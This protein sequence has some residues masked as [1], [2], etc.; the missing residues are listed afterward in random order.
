MDRAVTLMGRVLDGRYRVEGKIGEGGMGV[1]LAA[2]HLG[3][4]HRV[5]IKLMR[6]DADPVWRRR[7]MR[8]A[9]AASRIDSEHVARVFDVGVTDDG[10]PFLTMEYLEGRD[11]AD[12]MDD[13]PL[14][15]EDAVEYGIQ[16]C[17]ALAA[18]HD[19]GIV[20]RDVKPANLFVARREDGTSSVKLLDF[21][22]SKHGGELGGTLTG[23]HAVLGSP[24][25][26]SPEQLASSR[27][28]D[29]RADLWSLGATLFELLTLEHAFE[30]ASLAEL[31]TAIMRDPPRELADYRIDAPLELDVIIGQCLEKDRERR[32]ASARELMARLEA[33]REQPSVSE[34]PRS[35][36]SL[37]APPV[38]TLVMSPQELAE[39]TPLASVRPVVLEREPHESPLGNDVTLA[40]AADG[41]P[42]G[43]DGAVTTAPAR[44]ERRRQNRRRQLVAA[45]VGLG[46]FALAL[47]T[48][49]PPTPTTQL[50]PAVELAR[51]AQAESPIPFAPP[52]APREA[53]PAP[54]PSHLVPSRFSD[55]GLIDDA[56][57][58]QIEDEL[59]KA[60]V[61]LAT[62]DHATA[63]R[64][65]NVALQRLRDVGIR[66][67]ES[68]SSLGA[69]VT[70][71]R[72]EVEGAALLALLD[73]PSDRPLDRAAAERLVPELERRLGRAQLAYQQVRGWGV[74][75]FYRCAV[76]ETAALHLAVG[77]AFAAARANDAGLENREWLTRGAAAWLRLARAG[78][79][80]ALR[81]PAETTLCAADARDGLAGTD[82]V[83]ATLTARARR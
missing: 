69:R 41:E 32:I 12:I 68:V 25:F 61:A 56:H 9:Q 6:A 66:P 16:A 21:G 74:A 82:R 27:D 45:L 78:Y 42:I 4:G 55:S 71:L 2:R 34:R 75:S 44:V 39:D 73:A 10:S 28:V 64:R 18:A 83:L 79:R 70:L 15:V 23:T 58:R 63:R 13:G 72:G 76:A 19:L 53:A 81:V 7:F 47:D 5:A 65:A 8:E 24:Q 60:R 26:M 80:T 14:S 3:L 50:A 59:E 67:N 48:P 30:G 29:E 49:A 35:V 33:V 77:R 38:D 31:C 62:G 40:E 43:A 20:H 57:R 46:C 37:P 22:I 54:P 11:L 36:R 52:V 1:V 17:R 51:E